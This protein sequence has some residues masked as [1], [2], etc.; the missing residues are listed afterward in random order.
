MRLR[1]AKALLTF[2]GAVVFA[3]SAAADEPRNWDLTLGAAAACEPNYSGATAMSWRLVVWADGA[4]RTDGFGTIALDSGS[5]TIAPEVRWDVIDS[6]DLGLGPL[7]G[8]RSGRIDHNP[9][10][11]SGDHGTTLPPG[12]SS[13]KSS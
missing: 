13:V 10:F 5:L 11:P 6:S 4:Y 2:S 7:V 12:L 9:G 8:Y 1:T 3:T